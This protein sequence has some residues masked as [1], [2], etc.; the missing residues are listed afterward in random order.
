MIIFRE[1]ATSA[2][3]HVGYYTLVKFGDVDFCGGNKTGE[4][5]KKTLGAQSPDHFLPKIEQFQCQKD[6]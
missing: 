1:E 6:D 3:F 2:V 4:P 5:R